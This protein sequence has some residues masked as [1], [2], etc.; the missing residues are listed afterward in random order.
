M[1]QVVAQ[2][3]RRL[4]QLANRAAGLTAR[5]EIDAVFTSLCFNVAL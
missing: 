4:E 2:V 1:H 5:V 3:A